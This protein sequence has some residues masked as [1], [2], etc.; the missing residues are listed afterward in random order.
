MKCKD[1]LWPA[2]KTDGYT[3]RTRSLRVGVRIETTL[4]NTSPLD[5]TVR[6]SNPST[7]WLN[8][9]TILCF[10]LGD[11]RARSTSLL[12]CDRVAALMHAAT[13]T[14]QAEVLF[15]LPECEAHLAHQA[16][17]KLRREGV[18][19]IVHIHSPVQ[20]ANGRW[21]SMAGRGKLVQIQLHLSLAVYLGW[22]CGRK[23]AY[24]DVNTEWKLT[25]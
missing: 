15:G 21:L 20:D 17:F 6:H 7:S 25:R 16:D 12:D 24:G 5:S 14:I 22:S 1:S 18:R 23:A 11:A 2:T 4:E 8:H 19:R 13:P 3:T 9:L 10:M